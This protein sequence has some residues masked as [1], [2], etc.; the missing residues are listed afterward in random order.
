MAF[1][2]TWICMKL[3]APGR[4]F[5]KSSSASSSLRNLM[6]SAMAATSSAD[7]F[8]YSSQ[9][10]FLSAHSFSMLPESALS[11]ASC[12]SVSSR[13]FFMFAIST[14]V[15]PLR[16]DFSSIC[17]VREAIS[18]FFAATKDS[19]SARAVS[20]SV[21]VSF[22]SFSISSFIC[23]RIPTIS[24]LFGAYE[25]VSP[26][27]RKLV[28]RSRSASFMSMLTESFRSVEAPAVCRNDPAMPDSIAGIALLRAAMLAFK[29]AAVAL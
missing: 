20:S 13:S 27:S 18:F 10:T 8:E 1:V 19:Y 21:M 14:A 11:S 26:S 12:S 3:L 29:S 25:S 17:A 28:S 23:L 15:S 6:V 24:P 4:V 5:L 7:A 9:A 22:R 2:L 16:T